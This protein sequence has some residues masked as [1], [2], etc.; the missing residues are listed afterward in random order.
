M[1]KTLA[2]ALTITA[3]LVASDAF[4]GDPL[5]HG[6]SVS[7]ELTLQPGQSFSGDVFLKYDNQYTV[8]V[9]DITFEGVPADAPITGQFRGYDLDVSVER[10]W[11]G[12]RKFRTSKTMSFNPSPGHQL[13]QIL[14]FTA[15]DR[16]ISTSTWHGNRDYEVTITNTGHNPANIRVSIVHQN[17]VAF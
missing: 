16:S 17:N 11:N 3:S 2:L 15:Y 7:V 13:S 8:E 5:Q 1:A 10:F 12:D 4:A 9:Q 6:N 14:S